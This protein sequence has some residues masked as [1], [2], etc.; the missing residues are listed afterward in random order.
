MLELDP[1][2]FAHVRLDKGPTRVGLDYTS[3]SLVIFS[4]IFNEQCSFTSKIVFTNVFVTVA[5]NNCYKRQ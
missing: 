2:P 4:L 1:Y 3:S 5:K